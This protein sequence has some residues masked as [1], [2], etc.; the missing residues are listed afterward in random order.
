VSPLRLDGGQVGAWLQLPGSATAELMGSVG[1]DFVCVDQQHGLIGD[2]A[3]LPMLQGLAATGTPALVRVTTNEPAAIGRA[4]DRGAAGII[5]PLV[6]SPEEA[7]AAVAACHHPPRGSRSFGPTRGGWLRDQADPLCVVMVETTAALAALP[8]MLEVDDLDAVFIGPSD[9]AL[10][11][12]MPVRAQ[13][14]DPAYDDLLRSIIGPCRDA[15]MP[16]G[17]YCA[18]PTHARRF[19]DMG[20]TYV[21]LQSE[22]TMLRAAAAEHL[23]A[24]R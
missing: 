18:S 11:A 4:L 8:R 12:G 3:L 23:A 7:D 16:V 2:D 17:I 5:V 6:D 13:D 15:G 22:A 21:A 19:R 1:F 24:S 14:G 20:C 10:G 9:L